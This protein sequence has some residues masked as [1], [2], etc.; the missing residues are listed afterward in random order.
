M[1][2]L[3]TVQNILASYRSLSL[4]QIESVELMHRI[5]TKYIVSVEDALQLLLELQQ[6]Y[7]VLEIEAQRIG[8]YTSTYY[9]TNDQQ[10]YFAHVTG[11][12]PR[13]KVRERVYSQNGLKFFE[14][15]KKCN[16]GRT[17]KQRVAI[18]ENSREKSDWLHGRVPFHASELSPILVN[19]FDRVTLVNDGHTERVTLDFNIHFYTPSGIITPVNDRITIIELKQDKTAISPLKKYLRSK[20]IHP[21]GVSKFC[22]GLLLTGIATSYKRYK[23]KFFQFIKTQHGHDHTV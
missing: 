23:P 5:D 12:L 18:S 13:Y 7:H 2:L 21:N 22:V 6:G 4:E 8:T 17:L 10:M 14:V 16:K 20:G 1:V 11:R 9:D 15:K 19:T 3:D